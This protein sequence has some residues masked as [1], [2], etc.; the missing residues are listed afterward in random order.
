MPPIHDA[1]IIGIRLQSTDQ[2]TVTFCTDTVVSD[3]VF[4]G[5]V[6]YYAEAFQTQNIAFELVKNPV[7]S[8]TNERSL[9]YLEKL[10]SIKRDSF[11]VKTIL[12]RLGRGELHLFE[13]IATL[14]CWFVCI[15]E[16]CDWVACNSRA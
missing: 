3:L 10:G 9:D 8:V 1:N 13:L 5:V 4:T 12:D 6:M 14:G 7:G 16:S 11:L 2:V 15:A